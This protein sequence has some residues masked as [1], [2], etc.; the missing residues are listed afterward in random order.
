MNA[1]HYID[2]QTD[3]T[4]KTLYTEL[5]D[6]AALGSLSVKRASTIEFNGATQ[7]WEVE[8]D[9]E[10]KYSNPSRQNCLDW[11]HRHFNS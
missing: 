11:E 10:I 7:E 4:A 9:G 6:L 5:I 8:I 1:T 3:G 2:F